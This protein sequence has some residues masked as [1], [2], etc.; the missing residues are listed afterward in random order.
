MDRI[1]GVNTVDIG[2]GRRG[3]RSKDTVAGIPGTV[4]TATHMNAQQ[5]EL[6]ALIEGS[7]HAASGADLKQ[8]LRATR[9]QA[10]NFVTATNVGGTAGA[11][12]LAFTPTFPN[13]ASLLF[14][15][16]RFVAEAPAPGAVTIN[17]DGL[18]AVALNWFDG[19]ALAANEYLTNESVIC[20]HDGTA[21]RLGYPLSPTRV[22]ALINARSSAYA[23]LAHTEASGVNA[24]ATPVTG[25]WFTRKTN[26]VRYDPAGIVSLAS[27]QFTLQA[28]R[29]ILNAS[30]LG[31]ACNRHK[32]RLYNVTNA[33]EVSIGTAGNSLIDSA[34]DQVATY[35]LI[36][37]ELILSAATTYRID[38]IC[39]EGAGIGF[40]LGFGDGQGAQEIYTRIFI[41]KVA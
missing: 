15:P 13:L 30:I 24:G 20:H 39:Q 27:N 40:A 14:V 22:Q 1:T 32:A 5:E 2:G 12:T 23:L 6:M 21:F 37:A 11:I 7:G 33:L 38:Q 35:S 41:Q 26:T 29:Y 10:S 16:L 9:S 31:F 4:V 18:G 34:G 25:A 3:F 8:L 36:D 28:G 19:T 17:V